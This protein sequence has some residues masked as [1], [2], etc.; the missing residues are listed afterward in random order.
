MVEKTGGGMSRTQATHACRRL[1]SLEE[2]GEYLGLSYWAVRDLITARTL[3]PVQLPLGR[4]T[5]RRV[6][7]DRQDLDRL[8][9]QSKVAA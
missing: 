5:L 1:M 2:A 3:L 8:I 9:E 7:L 6:L 4:R